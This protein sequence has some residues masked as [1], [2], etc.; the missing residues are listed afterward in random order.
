[1][2]FLG[3]T[4][5]HDSAACLIVDGVIVADAAEER[6]SR[7]KHDSG[8]PASAIGYCLKAG[9]IT[10]TEVDVLAIAGQFMPANVS[11]HFI[12][13]QE[14]NGALSRPTVARTRL[15]MV[16]SSQD[17]PLYVERIRLAP[18]CRLLHVEHH[19][20]HAAAAYFT[21]GRSD[22]CLI[23]T[24][25]GIGDAVSVALW[26][27]ENNQIA[28]LRKWGRTASLGWFYGTVTEALGWQ[29]GDGEGTTMGLAAYGDSAKAGDGLAGFHPGFLNGELSTPCSFGPASSISINGNYHWH[30][31][32]AAAIAAVAARCGKENVAARAQEIIEQEVVGLL[33][34]W[35]HQSGIERLA[36]G[37]GLFLNVKLNQRIWSELSPA[38]HW[39]FP[40]PGDAGLAMGAALHAYHS[41]E[42]PLHSRRLESLSLGPGFSNEEIRTILEARQLAYRRVANPAR[43]AAR[44]L[45]DNK[46]VAWFQGRMESGPRALGN[47]SI[48]MSANRAE[49]KDILNNRVKFREGFRPFCPSILAE[50][51]QEYLEDG[52]EENFMMTSFQVRPQ[53]RSCIPAVVHVDGTLRPQTVS[54]E[55]CPLFHDLISQF[56]ESTGEHLV[57][58]TSFNIKGEPIV[59][60]P[61]EAISCF[62]DTGL[63]ALVIGDCVLTKPDDA[64]RQPDCRHRSPKD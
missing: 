35:L 55:T 64:A 1:M 59:C 18:G 56:A 5:G 29:H 46:A 61:R 17:L 51:K 28:P 38:E 60:H 47:R 57:L 53:R 48:L 58:N 43:E 12:L 41:L 63:D 15:M 4:F 25:D 16:G 11:R 33:R 2:I 9:G 13:S 24:M 40:N 19:L 14:Q 45:A 26:V 31:P 44:L 50:K 22:R 8:F 10:S 7:I 36:C 37:G 39:V 20:A 52:R 32:E 21:R 6:F 49:N 42:S 30:F 3:V 27:G 54:R 62:F 23:A 34:H